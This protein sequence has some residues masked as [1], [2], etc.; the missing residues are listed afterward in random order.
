MRII[1][2]AYTTPALLA[3][4][5]TVTRR[6]WKGTYA[7]SFH[8]GDLVAAYDKSPRSGGHQVATIRLTCEPYPECTADIPPYDY[9]NEGFQYME[10][11]GLLVQGIHPRIFW[12][13]WKSAKLVL[14]VVRFRIVSIT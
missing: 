13:S 7:R 14:W 6:E 2:F 3:R 9:E 11:V 12:R 1:S 5:K 10:E 4:R 8:A